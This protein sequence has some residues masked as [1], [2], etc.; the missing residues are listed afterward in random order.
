MPRHGPS[1][2]CPPTVSG[3]FGLAGTGE[4]VWCSVLALG[5]AMATHETKLLG[6]CLT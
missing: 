6:N 3:W 5:P 1:C 2:Q 4:G